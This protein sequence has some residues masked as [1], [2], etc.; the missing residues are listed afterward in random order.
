[1]VMLPKFEINDALNIMKKQQGTMLIGVPTMYHTLTLVSDEDRTKLST[2]KF[3]ISGGAGLPEVTKTKFEQQTGVEVIEGYGLSETSPVVCLNPFNGQSKADCIGK[4]VPHT[5]VSLRDLEDPEKQVPDGERGEVCVRGPQVM[6]GYWNNSD[7]THATMTKD[8][9]LRTGDV[10][11][12]DENG[13][14]YIVDRIKDIILCGGFNVYPKRIEDAIL[15]HPDVEEVIVIG[16]PDAHRGEKPMAF[17][18]M[19]DDATTTES[20]ILTFANAKLSKIEQFKD[21]QF[22]DDL[23]TTAVGKLSKKDLRDELEA[24]KT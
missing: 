24:E 7:A 16:I 20:E 10:A 8:G 2:M 22:R 14:C 3:A 19:N 11:M 9:F 4:P 17:V 6:M 18:T 23:P 21:I 12:F 1:M 13:F 5:E 15:Q